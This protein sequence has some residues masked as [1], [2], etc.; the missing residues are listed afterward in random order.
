MYFLGVRIAG[1]ERLRAFPERNSKLISEND[2]TSELYRLCTAPMQ[3][4]AVEPVP[5]HV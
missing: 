1:K 5:I 3:S 4:V 2:L